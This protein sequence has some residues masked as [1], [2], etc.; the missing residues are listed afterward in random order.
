MNTQDFKIAVVVTLNKVPTVKWVEFITLACGGKADLII[1]DD[2][3]EQ[4]LQKR[5]SGIQYVNANVYNRE[6]QEK[7]LVDGSIT[8]RNFGHYMAW[9]LE[10]DIIIGLDSDCN[11]P[12]DFIEKHVG[13]LRVEGYGWTNPIKQ[14]GVFP[15]GFPYSERSR[16]VT[17]NLGLWENVLD[18]NSKDVKDDVP[19]KCGVEG[20]L[21]AECY[22]PFSGLNWSMWR[23]AIPGFMFLHNFNVTIKDK[24]YSFINIGDIWGGYIFQKFMEKR[25]ERMTYGYP[26]VHRDAVID[27]EADMKAEEAMIEF[28]NTF[29][30]AVDSVM[31]KVTTSTYEDMVWQFAQIVAIDWKNTEWDSLM[32]TFE[33]WAD[34]FTKK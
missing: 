14:K 6:F 22:I 12:Q 3:P 8:S 13:A 25:N 17:A 5:L 27:K 28:E 11:V 31:E 21:V 34:L 15:R 19:S 16:K 10:Y 2:S 32:V 30:S 26:I 24:E 7:E 20:N 23:E 9:K 4:D 33:W 1:V 18:I 29:Y